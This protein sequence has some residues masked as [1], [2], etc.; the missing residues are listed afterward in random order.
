[1]KEQGIEKFGRLIDQNIEQGRYLSDR[2][3]QE[4]S[5]QQ[6]APRPINIV[7]FRHV[8]AGG[9]EEV[10]KNRNIEIMLRIQESGLAVPSDTTVQGV[11]CLRVAIN[12][13]RTVGDDLEFLVAETVRLGDAIVGEE[14]TG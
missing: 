8:G 14:G 6:V 2:I 3:A 5:L 12:N 7:C 9:S 11:H 13:H 4:P 1:M 10:L